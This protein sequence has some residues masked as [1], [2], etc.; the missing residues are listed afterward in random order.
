MNLVF[1]DDQFSYQLLRAVSYSIY[2]GADIGECFSTAYRIKE[3]DFESWH[4]EWLRTA[5]RL[6]R[7]GD[8][9]LRMGHEVSAREAY[10]RASNYYRTAEFFLHENPNDPRIIDTWRSSRECFQKAGQLFSPVFESVE[11][12]YEDTVL[13][14]YFFRARNSHAPRPTLILNTGFD[15]TA[16]ELYFD[17]VAALRRGYHC[18]TFDGP[19]QGQVIRE[20]GIHFR[21]DWENVITPVIDYLQER[22]EVDKD[23]IALFGLSLGGYFAPRAAA[24]DKRIDACVVSGGVYDMF[25]GIMANQHQSPADIKQFMTEK[26]DEFDTMI[27]DRAKSSSSLRWS[28]EDGMWKFAASTPHEWIMKAAEYNL[29]GCADKIT[30]PVLVCESENDH[31]F[32]GQSK[33]LF[34]ALSNCQKEFIFFTGEEGAGEHC[35]AGAGLLQAQR[36]Y[37]WLDSALSVSAAAA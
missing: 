35:Q 12:P 1:D 19:G 24:F 18:L 33:R 11:I 37:D 36:V 17:A 10:L 31:D 21:P 28:T 6:S 20:Q 34:D 8:D 9:S 15:G 13:P 22:P 2:S 14:G 23:H 5:D 3:G 4:Q 16:E 30:C 29:D 27:R 32:S 25:E 26:P 7:Y